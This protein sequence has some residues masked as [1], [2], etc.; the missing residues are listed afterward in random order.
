MS[1]LLKGPCGSWH[2]LTTDGMGGERETCRAGTC[3]L[4]AGGRRAPSLYALHPDVEAAR[5]KRIPAPA[6]QASAA[7]APAAPAPVPVHPLPIQAAVSAPAAPPAP[8]VRKIARAVASVTG[9]QLRAARERLGWSRCATGKASGFTDSTVANLEAWGAERTAPSGDQVWAVLQAALLERE[10][11]PTLALDTSGAS[12]GA[13]APADDAPAGSGADA[14]D[15]RPADAS[16]IDDPAPAPL[17]LVE[18][19]PGRSIALEPMPRPSPLAELHAGH[20]DALRTFLPAPGL[21][22]LATRTPGLQLTREA[23]LALQAVALLDQAV[24]FAT[25]ATLAFDPGAAA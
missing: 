22:D 17:A 7:P 18:P 20:V 1:T 25:P 13:A 24:R 14:A 19:G 6:A 10:A 5:A 12:A 3:A 21:V 16:A 2:D 8:K 15:I 4:G 11:A 9:A 23:V